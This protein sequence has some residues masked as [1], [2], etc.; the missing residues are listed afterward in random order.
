MHT[1]QV[2]HTIHV[3]VTMEMLRYCIDNFAKFNTDH[4]GAYRAVTKLGHLHYNSTTFPRWSF[5]PTHIYFK[6]SEDMTQF[7]LRFG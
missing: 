7:K 4:P 1:I 3:N 6:N 2:M 5:D